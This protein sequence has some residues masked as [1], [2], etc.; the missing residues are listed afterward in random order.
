MFDNVGIVIEESSGFD[1][2]ESSI[3]GQPLYF[4]GVIYYTLYNG[5]TCRYL[6]EDRIH[7]SIFIEEYKEERVDHP[8]S[9]PVE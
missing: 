6:C 8:I 1:N 2:L 7:E 3:A 9:E 4:N 5:T